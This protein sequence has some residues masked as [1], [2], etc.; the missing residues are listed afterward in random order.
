MNPIEKC[1]R[2][3]K[4]RIHNQ[5]VQPKTRAEMEEALLKAWDALPQEFI[6]KLILKQHFWVNEL[7]QRRG[8]STSN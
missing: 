8:W 2:W 6:N 3:I 7:V 1:W 4:N 5:V